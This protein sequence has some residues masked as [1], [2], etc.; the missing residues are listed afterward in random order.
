VKPSK[1]VV[2]LLALIEA[3]AAQEKKKD[4]SPRII[5]LTPLHVILGETQ[6]VRLRGLKLK[7]VTEIRTTPP[8]TITLKEKKDAAP[9]NGL[10]AKDVGD[11]ELVA[12]LTVPADCAAAAIELT[13]VAPSGNSETLKVFAIAKEAVAKEKEPNN[14]FGDAQVVDLS[15]PI[16]G[17]IEPD[18]DVDVYRV[19]GHSGT[20]LNVRIT[21]ATAGSLLDPV[22]SVFDAAG[23]LI[24]SVDDTDG[25]RD[26]RLTVTP[27]ADGP[28]CLVVC[29]AHDRGG[30]WHEYWLQFDPQPRIAF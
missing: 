11:Q 6:T 29:D 7:E 9:P 26:A 24:G 16:S 30:P 4:D 8:V 5:A 2:T 22:L 14:G 15:K 25:T 17:R 18:K 20:A 21:A 13:A 23:H 28:L 1:V 12:D 19:D 27:T 10:E 3:A